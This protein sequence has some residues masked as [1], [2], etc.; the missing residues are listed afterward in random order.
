MIWMLLFVVVGLAVAAAALQK[1]PGLYQQYNAAGDTW[2]TANIKAIVVS[3]GSS[4]LTIYHWF[5]K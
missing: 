1:Y 5:A 4:P 2:G 3:I